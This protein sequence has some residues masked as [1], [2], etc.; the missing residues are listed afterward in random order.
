MSN[1]EPMT[2][3]GFASKVKWEGG[4]IEALEY[5]LKPTDAPEGPIRIDVGNGHTDPVRITAA[6]RV[7]VGGEF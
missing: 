4:V 1:T 7:A 2:A 6:G 3:S 5:G